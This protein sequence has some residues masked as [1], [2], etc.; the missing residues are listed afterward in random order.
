MEVT[1][2]DIIEGGAELQ[3]GQP[4]TPNNPNNPN[5]PGQSF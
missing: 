3:E 4:N 2:L 1:D 5:N